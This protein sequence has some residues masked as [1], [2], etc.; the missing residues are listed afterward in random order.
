[1]RQVVP[2][3]ITVFQGRNHLYAPQESLKAEDEKG[4]PDGDVK[5][6]EGRGGTLWAESSAGQVPEHTRSSLVIE[7]HTG[8]KK[9]T[10]R[11][12]F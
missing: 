1:M 3:G 5:G 7:R 4:W 8:I 10:V 12:R 11:K 6:S 9:Q 2:Y